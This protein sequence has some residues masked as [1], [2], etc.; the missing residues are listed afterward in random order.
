MLPALEAT[1]QDLGHRPP[2][3]G[4]RASRRRGA[5]EQDS[6]RVLRADRGA[7]QGHARDPADGRPRRLARALPRGG[8]HRALR[9]HVAELTVEERRLG[10]NAVTEGWAMLLEHLTI[11]PVWLDRRLDFRGRR[12]LRRGRGATALLLAALLREA[13]VRARVPCGRRRARD[14]P[15]LRRAARRRAEDR[16]ERRRLPRGHRRGFYVGVSPL[17]G[18][19]GAAARRTCARSSA[20]RGSPREAGSLLRELWGEARA[21]RRRDPR[22]VTGATLELEAVAERVREGL[23][24]V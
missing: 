3:A 21:D 8:P 23:A 22:D 9:A 1:L 12:V 6:A 18:V 2:R 15:A 14:A 10:D 17:V 20:T 24:L 7:G 16:A 4:E 13:P 5:T 11:D 19:R